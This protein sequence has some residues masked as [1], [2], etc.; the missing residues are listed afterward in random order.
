MGS[1]FSPDSPFNTFMTLVFDLVVLNVLWLVCCIPVVTIGASTTALY[2]VMLKRVR[3]EEGYVL[4]GFFSAFKANFTETLPL[5]FLMLLLAALLS[6]DLYITGRW[7]GLPG[8]LMY[9][10]CL[11]AIFVAVG[12]YSYIW[13]LVARFRNT[14]RG[15]L[16]NAWRM[17]VGYLPKTVALIVLNGLP[18]ALL[19][20]ATSLFARIFWFY[21]AVGG[22]LTAYLA[23]RLI[24]PIFD[25]LIS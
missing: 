1:F 5:T 23:S 8:S 18:F 24:N 17:A 11:A 19:L 10:L 6:T 12:M 2:T 15:T 20:F 7:E 25:N 3:N 16:N 13:P 22:S 9:G 21:L 14:F 4:R